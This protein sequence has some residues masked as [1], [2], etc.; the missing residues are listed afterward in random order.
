[1]KQSHK[2]AVTQ[3]GLAVFG[4]LGIAA[5]YSTDTAIKLYAPLVGICSQPFWFYMTYTKRMWGAFFV[6]F[7]YTASWVYGIYR[8]FA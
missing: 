4:V 1:M 8:N 2:D 6:T 5:S 3:I 7:L